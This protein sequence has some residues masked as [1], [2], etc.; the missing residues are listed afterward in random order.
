MTATRSEAP[1]ISDLLLEVYEVNVA[2]GWFDQARTFGDDIA[3]LHSEVSEAVEAYEGEDEENLREE[4]ADVLVR[5]L[6]TWYRTMG[7]D[8]APLEKTYSSMVST[9]ILFRNA[10][11]EVFLGDIAQL[12]IAISRALESFRKSWSIEV[13]L[14]NVLSATFLI[15]VH[16]GYA[17]RDLLAETAN[18]V[19]INRTRGYRHGGK[20]L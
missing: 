5:L 12:N 14:R 2:N 6:D 17:P 20:A 18:K 3:L 8:G 15:W 4:I 9:S 19:A 1:S 16:L 10:G 7:D 13:A 11:R